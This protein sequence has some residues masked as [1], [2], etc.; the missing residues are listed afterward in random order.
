MKKYIY[1][2]LL[3]ACTILGASAQAAYTDVPDGHW[4]SEAIVRAAD[5]GIMNG[6]EDG[7]FGLGQEIK[8]CEFAA[9]LCRLM[10]WETVSDTAPF[11]DTEPGAWYA[12]SVNT[13]YAHNAAEQEAAFRPNAAITR[14]EM[15]VML[16]KALGY[17]NLAA[18]AF[19][20]PFTDLTNNS[21]YISVAYDLGIVT[22]KSSD[23]FDPSGPALREEGAAM[24]TRLSDKYRHG[25]SEV[26]GFYAI[27]SWSQRE[28]A[29]QMD[30]ITFGWSRLEYAPDTGAYLNTTGENG[31][32]W[33]IPDS[34]ADATAY[35]KERSI[36]QNLG[37]FLADPAVCRAILT[38]PNERTRAVNAVMAKV[39]EFDGV[40]ID[41]EGMKGEELKAG[42]TAF[43][44][45]L[46]TAL[47]EKALYT[48]VHPVMRQS[49]YYDAYD[50]RAIGAVS[51]RV[52]LM[53]HDYA[54]AAMDENLLNTDFNATPVTP[55]NQVYYGLKAITDPVS[56]VA[57]KSKLML[58][59]SVSSSA[60]WYLTDGK[61]S[62]PT[63]VHPAVETIVK[64]LAQPDTRISYS[65]KYRNPYAFY[66]DDAGKEVLIW[67]EN[68]QSLQ[69]KIVLAR[70]FSVNAV[71]IWRIG[72]MASSPET[73]MDIP[74]AVFSMR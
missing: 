21:G 50:Y 44:Q 24:M 38:D 34:S 71:S 60:A 57:D 68:E 52:I 5:A 6:R 74:N 36:P 40:T 66:R 20:N 11:N 30:H 56:G 58:G 18:E 37:V 3:C 13:L 33:K 12:G 53:A 25:L 43:L 69:D 49:E 7:S 9:M 41:F 62:D 14:E 29:A 17:S 72:A 23:S 10:G 15:A 63:P 48:A 26:H 59:L 54:P 4:A 8:R 46:R 70:M 55:F 73:G 67:Y 51:D 2:G 47:G 27:S 31:N 64:R 39:A 61:I 19:P 65:E 28:I 42:L 45:E 1:A 16:V 32:S 22:G 35:F